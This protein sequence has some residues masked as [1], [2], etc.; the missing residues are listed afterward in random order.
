MATEV[1]GA[2]VR[3]WLCLPAE[4]DS[5]APLMLWIHGG[6]FS[7][8]NA[9]SWRWNPWVA[10]AHGWAVL[11]PDPALSTGYGPG[12]IARA[13]PHRAGRVWADL[14]ALLET[15]LD[16][17]DVDGA[18]T[19]CLGAS[20]GGYMTNWVAGHTDRF[21]AIVT[22]SGSWALDQKND[23]ADVAHNWLTWFGRPAE[24]PDWYAENSPHHFADRIRTPML[25]THGNRD[26][27]VPVGEALRLWWDLVSRWD[28]DPA[29]LPHRFLN[30]TGENHWI[31]SPANYEIWYGTVLGFCGEHVLGRPWTRPDLL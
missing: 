14:E 31:L 8:F 17:S 15:V 26:Y 25:I 27:R 22:H 7:S 6:P 5:P 16:R 23:T 28:G 1:D 3:G 18:R 9:W 13:W 4:G 24:H 21:G 30:F 19:A 2:T 10:V 29:E 12:F 11:M 20:F